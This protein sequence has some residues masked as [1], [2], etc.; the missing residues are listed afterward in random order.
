MEVYATLVY[1]YSLILISLYIYGYG[2]PLSSFVPIFNS[3]EESPNSSRGNEN[4]SLR[5]EIIVRKNEMKLRKREIKV[6]KNFSV[7]P[8]G[9]KKPHRGVWSFLG[10]AVEGVDNFICGSEEV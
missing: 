9:N 2:G 7:A 3:S 1:L 4:S 6:P 5:V 8:E 10:G